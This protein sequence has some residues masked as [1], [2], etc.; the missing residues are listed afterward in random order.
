MRS[1][2]PGGQHQNKTES[3][4][5][6]THLPTGVVVNCRDERSQHKNKAK[7]MRILRSRLFDQ[8][9]E[10]ARTER[11]QTRRD[12]DRLRRPLA[13]DPDL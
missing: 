4:V 9:Q 1:G 3:G 12:T 5:R 8:M 2:G 7:A 13:E 6:I 11:D 10:K